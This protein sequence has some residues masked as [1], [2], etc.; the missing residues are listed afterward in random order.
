MSFKGGKEAADSRWAEEQAKMSEIERQSYE[1]LPTETITERL[2]GTRR[3]KELVLNKTPLP[4]LNFDGVRVYSVS[5]PYVR[6][7]MGEKDPELQEFT[8]DGHSW[9]YK[10]LPPNE[11]WLEEGLPDI[12]ENYVHASN[13]IKGMRDKGFS[14][15]NAHDFYANPIERQVRQNPDML[16]PE[17][18]K[19]TGNDEVLQEIDEY[20]KEMERKKMQKQLEQEPKR[21]MR[22][23]VNRYP[24]YSALTT[25][26]Y[27][28]RPLRPSS[29]GVI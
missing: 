17:I 11:L 14:Y 1:Q 19:I 28:G 16:I 23:R 10:S 2:K 29:L 3:A 21:D 26:R 25:R 4:E 24:Q 15:D 13:E 9:R 6:T 12:L 8:I 18:N 7:V 20:K 5:G 27:L 22:L